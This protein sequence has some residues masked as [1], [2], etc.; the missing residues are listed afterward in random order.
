MK[1]YNN[2]VPN[3]SRGSLPFL[4]QKTSIRWRVDVRLIYTESYKM[5][6]SL[7]VKDCSNRYQV[8]IH[9]KLK[10]RNF[11]AMPET[12]NHRKNLRQLLQSL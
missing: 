6:L 1:V 11:T 9:S 7:A 8:G 5:Y 12:G 4:G 10:D 3:I 2:F